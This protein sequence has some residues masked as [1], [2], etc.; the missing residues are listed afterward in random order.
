MFQSE[1]TKQRLGFFCARKLAETFLID[2][3]FAQKMKWK[4]ERG[5]LCTSWISMPESPKIYI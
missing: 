2:F 5:T 1:F 4:T 3:F